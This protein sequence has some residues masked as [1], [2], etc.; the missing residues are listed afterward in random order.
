MPVEVVEGRHGRLGR[1]GGLERAGAEPELEEL[2]DA[3]AAL[4]NEIRAGER[5]GHFAVLAEDADQT[6]AD[7]DPRAGRQQKAL[8][9]HIGETGN[10][11]G[12]GVCVQRREDEMASERGMDAHMRCL[13]I[14][15]FA[16]HDHIGIL[17]QER[18]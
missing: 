4:T 7:D 11:A 17:A 18:T 10:R 1:N 6:L 5:V 16:D 12:R 14:A 3:G 9:P 2:L 8:D 13:G 15:H